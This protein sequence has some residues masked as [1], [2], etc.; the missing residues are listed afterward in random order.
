MPT[1]KRPKPP[2]GPP[3]PPQVRTRRFD[4][5]HGSVAKPP[6]FLLRKDRPG[7]R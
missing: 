1:G 5:A 3:D 2:K 4:R 6:Y 7:G